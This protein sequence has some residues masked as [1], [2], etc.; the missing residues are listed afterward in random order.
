MEVSMK[1]LSTEQLEQI[2]Q[3]VDIVDIIDQFVALK[4]RGKNH[5][6]YCPFHDE[7]TPSF[8]VSQEKQLYKCFS[9]GRAGNVFS[10]L[11]EK[12]GLTF[13]QSVKKVIDLA[14][15]PIRIDDTDELKE[16]TPEQV[17]REML[18]A[19][20][21]VAASFY[22][23]ILLHTT[24]GQEALAY[25]Q[26]R[27]LT[28][29]TIDTFG[30]G[31]SPSHK[32][33][34]F[35][36]LLSKGY[37]REIIAQSGLIVT[38]E[39]GERD[40]FT[41]RIMVPLRNEKGECVAFSGRIYQQSDNSD[42]TKHE[43]K[44][45]NSPETELFQKSY[46]LY[47]MDLARGSI[48]KIDEVVLAEG[49]MDVIAMHQAGITNVVAS[50]GTSLTREQLLILRKMTRRLCFVYDGDSAGIK[51]T[52]RAIGLARQLDHFDMSIV[53]MDN[54][55]DPDEM[56][57][58]YGA[59]YLLNHIAHDRQSVFQFY[60]QYYKTQYILDTQQG[61][62]DYIDALLLVL[63]DEK[64]PTARSMAIGELANEFHVSL[65]SLE[66]QY[67][68]LSKSVRKKNGV[69]ENA[70]AFHRNNDL[71]TSVTPQQKRS[72]LEII[73]RQLLKRLL[74]YPEMISVLY[75]KCHDFAFETELYQALFL[76][77]QGF[78]AERQ[79]GITFFATHVQE[80]TQQQLL[81]ELLLDA[82]GPELS[83]LEL[84]QML[85]KQQIEKTQ[86][87]MKQMESAINEAVK[88]QDSQR[89][90]ELLI[91]FQMLMN[92]KK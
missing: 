78:Y 80:L 41:Q 14:Q 3:S 31:V 65:E 40:R 29:E 55:L 39:N 20:H 38:F 60:K 71:M 73:E 50:M 79:Q 89:V 90:E 6:G 8:T 62:L 76:N 34:L 11:M 27:G 72:A 45:L 75:V 26:Q 63:I 68:V 10:F 36:L 91:A 86:V 19:C 21:E 37:S 7:R 17:R 33:M 56:I 88:A 13:I 82:N 16:K 23:H 58:K 2:K 61:R 92:N 64:S 51:A 66:Q 18:V 54:G 42:A 32:S 9:C 77:F 81:S 83:E 57:Q 47:N 67:E 24:E 59:S 30:I 53:P 74:L 35:D 48:R 44:Y 87:A 46:F 5:F 49:Y 43:P 52:D 69:I 28:R 70:D 1:Q 15:L 4:K 84:E 85:H 12:D 25:L 22:H